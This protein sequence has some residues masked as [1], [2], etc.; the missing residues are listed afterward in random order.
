MTLDI[1]LSPTLLAMIG[2][3]LGAIIGSFLNVVVYRLPLIMR[4]AWSNEAKLFLGMAPDK[5]DN[6]SLSTPRSHCPDCGTQLKAI[7][8]IPVLSLRPGKRKKSEESTTDALIKGR[9]PV[10]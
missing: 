4:S 9:A 2:L 10:R 6:L 8:N 3:L 1:Y 7:H 5:A